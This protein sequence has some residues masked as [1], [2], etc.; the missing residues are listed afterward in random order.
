MNVM[1]ASKL[2]IVAFVGSVTLWYFI[3]PYIVQPHPTIVSDILTRSSLLSLPEPIDDTNGDTGYISIENW[4]KWQV[5]VRNKPDD[6]PVIIYASTGDTISFQNK[7]VMN[8]EWRP[9]YEIQ[10]GQQSESQDLFIK[11]EAPSWTW[12][13]WGIYRHFE[14]IV[15]GR[16]IR[17]VPR[18]LF[19][20]HHDTIED[21]YGDVE[22]KEY[23]VSRLPIVGIFT[24]SPNYDR[25]IIQAYMNIVTLSV[26]FLLWA[27][28]PPHTLMG[29]DGDIPK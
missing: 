20:L 23:T 7:A 2:L 13:N 18:F 8:M 6:K 12:S 14:T 21:L 10:V 15:T 17:I 28:N 3:T 22:K 24:E 26:I 9:E 16:T 25:I 11:V 5:Y 1:C 4:T 27:N 19:G 29:N